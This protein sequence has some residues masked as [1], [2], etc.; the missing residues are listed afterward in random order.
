LN[1]KARLYLNPLILAN[2]LYPSITYIIRIIEVVVKI[3][4]LK[5]VYERSQAALNFGQSVYFENYYRNRI[6]QETLSVST[7][8][9]VVILYYFMLCGRQFWLNNRQYPFTYLRSTC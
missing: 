2:T 7:L 3:Y 6:I 4:L 1:N 5:D 8:I 9:T